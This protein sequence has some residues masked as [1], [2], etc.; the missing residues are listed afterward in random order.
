MKLKRMLKIIGKNLLASIYGA[1]IGIVVS[2]VYLT[3]I[4]MPQKAPDIGLAIIALLPVLLI[5]FAFIGMVGGG[6]VGIISFQI[7]KKYKKN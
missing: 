7:Y 3:K 4:W 1:L 2:I 6:I 5:L